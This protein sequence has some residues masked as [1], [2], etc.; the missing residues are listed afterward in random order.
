[1]NAVAQI[2]L[3]CGGFGFLCGLGAGICDFMGNIKFTYVKKPKDKKEE[4]E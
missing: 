2:I 3:A 1:M 4:E